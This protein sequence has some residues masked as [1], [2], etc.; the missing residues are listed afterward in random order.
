MLKIYNKSLLT[1]LRDSSNCLCFLN[2]TLYSSTIIKI[3]AH[4]KY[5]LN[6]LFDQL[7]SFPVQ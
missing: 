7:E 3:S 5:H 4:P 6:Q 1:L 2:S